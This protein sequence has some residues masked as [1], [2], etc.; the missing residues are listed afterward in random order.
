VLDD[1]HEGA[2]HRLG[3]VAGPGLEADL[4]VGWSMIIV[5]EAR[6]WGVHTLTGR[7]C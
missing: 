2:A 5:V 4:G 3:H 6:P 1:V 7:L